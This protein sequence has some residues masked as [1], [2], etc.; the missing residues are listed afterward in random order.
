MQ[1]FLK[2]QSLSLNV[3]IRSF[4]KITFSL[5][6]F[7]FRKQIKSFLKLTKKKNLL[8]LLV[9]LKCYMIM[10]KLRTYKSFKVK[11]CKIFALNHLYQFRL[12]KKRL[13]FPIML[14]GNEKHNYVN[15]FLI[16]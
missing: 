12:R 9:F 6:G 14:C 10:Q 8:I 15:L 2:T 11:T 5:R 13:Y 16:K 1:L 4:L 3:Y 7:V